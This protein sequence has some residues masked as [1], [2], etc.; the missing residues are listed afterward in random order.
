LYW[1]NY[2]MNTRVVILFRIL[3]VL[4]VGALLFAA[5]GGTGNGTVAENGTVTAGEV[6]NPPVAVLPDDPAPV[7]TPIEPYAMPLPAY[8]EHNIHLAVHPEED[9]SILITGISRI[10]FTNRLDE[11]MYFAEF[12]LRSGTEIGYAA[13]DNEPLY[14]EKQAGVLVL[15]FLDTPVKPKETVQLVLQYSA[16]VLRIPSPTGG[17]NIAMWFGDFTPVIGTYYGVQNVA[18]FNVSITA[19][20]EYIVVAA[21]TRVEEIQDDAGRTTRFEARQLRDFAFA[22]SPYFNHAHT[23]T[24]TGIDIHL[25]HFTKALMVETVLDNARD[26]LSHFEQ[27]VGMFPLGHITLIEAETPGGAAFSQVIFANTGHMRLRN[28]NAIRD[29]VGR[30]WFGGI[31]GVEPDFAGELI[32]LTFSDNGCSY[33]LNRFYQD[34]SFRTATRADFEYI[35]EGTD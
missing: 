23:T 32:S 6:P 33:A 15:S 14:W 35:M 21:G 22:L 28:F 18:N 25:Y 27:S 24:D 20:S 30:Q 31:V 4:A 10:T 9:G 8:D 3:A 16:T 5:C 11:N 7:Y 13:K 34:F 29:G 26:A 1:Y 17:N 2:I 19:P 12:I